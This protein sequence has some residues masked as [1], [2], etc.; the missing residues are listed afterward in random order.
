MVSFA[1]LCVQIISL[2]FSD[3]T[4]VSVVEFLEFFCSAPSARNAR[5]AATAVRLSLSVLQLHDGTKSVGGSAAERLAKAQND[6]PKA[7]SKTYKSIA[8]HEMTRL[9]LACSRL[10]NIWMFVDETLDITFK[11]INEELRADGVVSLEM[12]KEVLRDIC[13]QDGSHLHAVEKDNNL[14]ANSLVGI[15]SVDIDLISERFEVGGR[16]NFNQF[17]LYFRGAANLESAVSMASPF[18]C[19]SYVDL[20]SQHLG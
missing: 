16:V 7:P 4:M 11:D 12:F 15:D 9:E 8:T 17:I 5:A 6:D 2:R 20:Y 1:G 3:G 14:A 10:F 18:R 13:G 19:A